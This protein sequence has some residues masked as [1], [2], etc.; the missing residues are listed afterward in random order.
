ML[1]IAD[2]HVCCPKNNSGILLCRVHDDTCGNLRTMHSI[3][4][5]NNTLVYNIHITPHGTFSYLLFIEQ[6]ACVHKIPKWSNTYWCKCIHE[7]N[8]S[9]YIIL[10]FS[11]HFCAMDSERGRSNFQT[12]Y[13][14][15][16]AQNSCRTLWY[17][18][19]FADLACTSDVW[20]VLMVVFCVTVCVYIYSRPQ[21]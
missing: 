1:T 13:H 9:M 8:D 18:I 4:C 16:P 3:G 5:V 11:H 17:T 10:N 19:R 6:F 2:D 15:N 12:E 14:S 20:I 21:I 7:S